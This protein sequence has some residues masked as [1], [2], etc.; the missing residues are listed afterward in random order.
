MVYPLSRSY[1]VTLSKDDGDRTSQR[2]R[3]G[4]MPAME[5]CSLATS[6]EL[7][8]LMS[9]LRNQKFVGISEGCFINGRIHR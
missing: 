5:A 3:D 6:G 1:I 2:I 9:T 7:D 8:S 4:E